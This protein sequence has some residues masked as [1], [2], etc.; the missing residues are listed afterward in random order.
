MRG[1]IRLEVRLLFIPKLP[2]VLGAESG[3]SF[4]PKLEVILRILS[5]SQWSFMRVSYTLN[6]LM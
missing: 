3:Y 5:Q 4:D 2:P 6:M 1:Q